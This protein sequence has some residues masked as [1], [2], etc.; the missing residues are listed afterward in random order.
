MSDNQ[1]CDRPVE[2]TPAMIAE[3]Q[4]VFDSLAEA[5]SPDYLVE[6]IYIA[7][8]RTL[9]LQHS[10]PESGQDRPTDTA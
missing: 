9:L 6:Q 4:K 7:M 2:V 1:N 3:G 8:V 10:H 5:V